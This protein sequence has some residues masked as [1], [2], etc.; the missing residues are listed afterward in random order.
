LKS[1]LKNK[2]L[3]ML[4][5]L[6][7]LVCAPP[8]FSQ[9]AQEAYVGMKKLQARCQVGVSYRDYSSVLVEAKLPLN[10]FLGSPEAAEKQD[11]AIALQRVMAHYEYAGRVWSWKFAGRKLREF[12]DADEEREVMNAYPGT[13][14]EGY[15]GGARIRHKLLANDLVVN[16]IFRTASDELAGIAYPQ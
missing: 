2:H 14:N 12:L 1:L 10:L 7:F 3:F 15:S 4:M 13:S 6:I 8:A 16:F 11:L 9:T 5:I